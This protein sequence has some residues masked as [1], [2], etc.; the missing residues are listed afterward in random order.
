MNAVRIIICQ[1]EQD[2]QE[3]CFRL[4]QD[5]FHCQ[6]PEPRAEFVYWDA[7]HASPSDPEMIFRGH[8]VVIGRRP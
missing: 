5:Q 4:R 7:T 1:T 8:F 3:A 6:G 2:A